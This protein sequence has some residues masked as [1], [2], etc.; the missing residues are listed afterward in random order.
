MSLHVLII[1]L[2]LDLHVSNFLKLFC[3]AHVSSPKPHI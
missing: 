1:F 2:Y 3:I